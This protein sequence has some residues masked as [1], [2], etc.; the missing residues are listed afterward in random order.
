MLQHIWSLIINTYFHTF[1]YVV[2][3]YSDFVLQYLSREHAQVPFRLF[4]AAGMLLKGNEL[5]LI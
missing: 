5:T 2:F 4:L 3:P 1:S